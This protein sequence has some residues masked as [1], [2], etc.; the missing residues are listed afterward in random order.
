MDNLENFDN[1]EL[2]E[3][4]TKTLLRDATEKKRAKL[5]L[6]AHW[7]RV[8]NPPPIPKLS[9][10]QLKAWC[11]KMWEQKTGLHWIETPENKKVVDIL[12]RYFVDDESIE[13]EGVSLKKGIMLIG[14]VGV[15]KTT[16][17]QL[18]CYNP[19]ASFSIV[20]CRNIANEFAKYGTEVIDNY[21]QSKR[22]SDQNPFRHEYLGSCFDDLGTENKR[23]NFGNE[24]NVMEEIILGRYDNRHTLGI[25]T[26]FTTNLAADQ[27]AEAY[28]DRVRSRLREMMNV[29]VFEG[30]TDMRK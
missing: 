20:S 22:G 4:E 5:R 24:A 12:S 28:G 14:G 25:K 3:E 23:K 15:G 18:F 10:E 17:M 7:E 6:D 21:S 29:F 9:A 1:V 26:H 11:I 13:N 19:K 8:K 27:I 30:Q 16:I 2:T